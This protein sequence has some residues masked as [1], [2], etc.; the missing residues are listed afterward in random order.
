MT[1]ITRSYRDHQTAQGVV[2]ELER[3]GIP[4][5]DI[6][7]ISNNTENWHKNGGADDDAG[8]GAATGAGVGAALGGA[9]GLLAGLGA[10]AIPGL[11][12]VVAAG[13]LASTAVGAAAGGAAGGLI[14]AL[15][16]A[17]VS[18]D[19]A[20]YYAEG[21][22]RG[23]TLVV[24]RTKDAHSATAQKIMDREAIDYTRRREAW[25]KEGWSGYDA[26]APAYT[27]EQIRAWRT[28]MY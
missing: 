23:D 21:V 17:G 13:W 15:A 12:P 6:S 4:T 19:E 7:I 5:A 20:E 16:D 2:R 18:S 22:R 8:D 10:M 3:A 26:D 28:T 14:G 1:T 11:G 25:K 9:A 27:P 24:V